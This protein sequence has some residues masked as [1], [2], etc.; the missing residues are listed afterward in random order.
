MSE[1]EIA[2]DLARCLVEPGL[3]VEATGRADWPAGRPALFLDRDGTVN[4]DTDYPSRPEEIVLREDTVAIVRAGNEAEIP[5]VV[6]SN[7][8]GIARGYFGWREFAAVNVRV[9]DLLALRGCSVDLV[10]ACAY[11][12]SGQGILAIPDHPMRK[13]NPGML[14]LARDRLGLDLSRSIMVGDKR[15]DMEAAYRAGLSEGWLIGEGRVDLPG[16][17]V[18]RLGSDRDQ[19]AL[20]KALGVLGSVRA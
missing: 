14:F 20:A 12:E 17:A 18:R 10:I 6:V 19:R 2:P 7:Q 13:P 4:V 11:H 16:F 1:S 8:S 15:S 5:V 9:L 3:W